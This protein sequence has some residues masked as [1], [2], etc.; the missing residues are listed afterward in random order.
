MDNTT[1]LSHYMELSLL[2]EALDCG[3][4]NS[5]SVLDMLMSSKKEQIKKIHPYAITPPSKDG[6]RWQTFYKGTDGK[7]KN[8]KAQTE[9]DLLNKLIPLYFQNS[10]IDKLTFHKLYEEWLEYKKTVTNSP[11]TIK[12]HTQHYSKYFESSC[13]HA[14]KIK[15]INELFLES[16]CNRIV[17]DFNLSRKEWGNTKTILN[18]MFQYA[19]RKK[20][21]SENPMDKIQI[22]VKFK[23]IVRKTGKTETYNTDELENLNQYLD[24]MYTET[25]DTVFLA[26]KLNFLLGLR[27]GELAALKW[28]DLSDE[29]HLHIVREEV[30]NQITNQCEVVEHTKTNC[31]RFVVLVPKAINLLQK[32]EHTGNYIFM[33]KGER[34]R[35]RQIAYVLEKYAERQGI[36]TKS[37]HKMRKTYASNLNAKGV[38]LDSIRELLGHSN[39][40]TT[41]GY[42]LNPLTEKETYDLI[43]K[44]L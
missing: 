23:Q 13:L 37:T 32:I 8:I 5:D 16:E 2:K 29:N 41:L 1:K 33:R 20:Y 24:R 4:L 42:I 21:L 11:N 26:V 30:R 14:M 34:I 19:V 9:E 17:K 35:A 12:R 40:T 39:P 10:Y 28:E 43:T 44:A 3:I 7:R 36:A 38:P 31:D 27:V 25:E 22:H 18:G 15:Q 6:G